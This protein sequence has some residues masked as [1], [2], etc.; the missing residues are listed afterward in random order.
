MAGRIK[1]EDVTYIRD[2]SAIDDLL[3]IMFSLKMLAVVRKKD[4][5]HF[6]MKKVP[7]F[8]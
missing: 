3:G 6:M 2:H 7:H 8:M 1:D 4:C 5:V